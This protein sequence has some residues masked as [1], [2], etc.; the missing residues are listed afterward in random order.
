MKY[1]ASILVDGRK[2]NTKLRGVI[3]YQ[4]KKDRIILGHVDA[5][6]P[7]KWDQENKRCM[8]HTKHGRNKIAA[9]VINREIDRFLNAVDSFFILHEHDAEEPS[10]WAVS[11]YVRTKMGRRDAE[12]ETVKS[13]FPHFETFIRE[14]G[15]K[16]SWGD[17]NVKKYRTLMKDLKTFSPNLRYP[18]INEECINNFKKYL[19]RKGNRNETTK[20]KL[21]QFK[22]YLD[23]ARQKGLCPRLDIDRFQPKLK[24]TERPVIFLTW[25]ELMKVYN[26]EFTD[27]QQYLERA[28]DLFCFMAFTGLRYSDLAKLEKSHIS[29]DKLNGATLKTTAKI[30]I[31]LNDYSRAILEKYKDYSEINESEMPNNRIHKKVKPKNLAL[32][33]ISSQKLNVYIKEFAKL[34]GIDEPVTFTYYIGAV[35]K[36]VTQP[37]YETLSCHA[38]RRTFICTAFALNIPLITVMSWSGHKTYAGVRPYAAAASQYRRLEMNKFNKADEYFSEDPESSPK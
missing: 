10:I 23:W 16:E 18:D 9:A 17:A 4:G 21:V 8:P 7:S 19:I 26:H 3:Y 28:R 22:C 1:K 34:L 29:Y 15:E 33:V 12:E 14:V 20:K 13:I 25:S 32:P 6:D 2:E 24:T 38:A 11:Q 30:D 36:D 31:E 27:K 37:K 5:D 35:R